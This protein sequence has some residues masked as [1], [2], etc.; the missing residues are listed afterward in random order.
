MK[1]RVSVLKKVV[2]TWKVEAK[3]EEDARDNYLDGDMV[4]DKQVDS[5]VIAVEEL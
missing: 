2:E 4:Y 1:Y 3:D 5:E